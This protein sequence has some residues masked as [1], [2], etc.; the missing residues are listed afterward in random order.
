MI[1]KNNFKKFSTK[2]FFLQKLFDFEFSKLLHRL[3]FLSLK[4]AEHGRKQ[5]SQDRRSIIISFLLCNN[6]LLLH[7]LTKICKDFLCM[8]DM[9]LSLIII[10]LIFKKEKKNVCIIDSFNV[11]FCHFS[12]SYERQTFTLQHIFLQFFFL[13]SIFGLFFISTWNEHINTFFYPK[14]E[15]K[16]KERKNNGRSIKQTTTT[17]NVR[18]F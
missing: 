13:F 5:K 3:T 18:T 6:I 14:K 8:V 10:I 16:R 11:C 17:T 15:K 2:T 7:K 1:K 9:V 12:N 4:R